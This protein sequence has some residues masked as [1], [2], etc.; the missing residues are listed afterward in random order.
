MAARLRVGASLAAMLAVALTAAATAA[1]E[2]FPAR[3]ITLVVGAAPGSGTDIGAR[4]LA[5]DMAASLGASVV[6]NSAS[7]VA[8]GQ[9]VA[10]SLPGPSLG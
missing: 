8:A 10:A 9:A 4:L 3:P 6:V 7:S 5:K 2:V 1:Q